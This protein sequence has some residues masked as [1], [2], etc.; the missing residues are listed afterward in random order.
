MSKILTPIEFQNLKNIS[1]K[2]D[3]DKVEQ[4]ITDGQVDLSKVIGTAFFYD[5]EKNV[6]EPEYLDL[7]EGSE[8]IQDDLAYYQDGIKALLA[9]FAYSRYLWQININHTPFGAVSKQYDDGQTTDRHTIKELVKQSNIDAD[10]KWQN[11]KGYLNINK[12]T[13]KVWA[14]Q[15]EG[16]GVTNNK[17]VGLEQTRF[18]FLSSG[19]K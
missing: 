13:F 15:Q 14:K 7:I 3:T 6:L 19:N 11:I 12:E 5:L 10:S 2:Y 4:A 1:R 18:N 17:S 16:C 8:F 9:E